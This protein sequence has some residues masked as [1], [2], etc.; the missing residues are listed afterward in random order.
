MEN[1]SQTLAQNKQNEYSE[2]ELESLKVAAQNNIIDFSIYTDERYNPSWLHEEIGKVLESAYQETLKG[3][4]VRIIL[5][6]PPRHGKSETCSIKFPAYVLGRSPEFPIMVSSYS[7]DLAEDFGSKTRD[8]MNSEAYQAVF[9]TRLKQDTKAKG[10]WMTESKGGY[11]S[12]G[13]GGSITGKGFKIGIIDD[14][15]KN[16]KEADSKLIR[17]NVYDWYKSTFYTRQEGYGAIIVIMTR[18]HK[19]DLVGRLLKKQE[20]DEQNPDITEF[21]AWEVIKFPA[22]AINDEQHRKAGEA[23]WK[24]KFSLPMLMNTKN[25]IGS[26][27]WSALYQQEPIASENQEFKEE[28]FQYRTIEE[29]LALQTY[30]SLTIDTAMS[31]N[32]ENDNTG[33]CI[34]FNDRENKWNIKAWKERISPKELI[35]RLFYLQE[36]WNLDAIGVEETI[37]L[38]VVQPFL[39]DEMR[40]RNKFLT[41]TPLKHNGT[42]KEL[43]IRSILPRYESKSVYHIK[44]HC[45]DLEEEQLEFPQS[46]HDDVLDAEAYQTQISKSFQPQERPTYNLQRPSFR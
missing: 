21:D 24:E 20:A 33:F 18:W 30:R 4:K 17:D 42:Q 25:S 28:F 46:T 41:I 13:V 2:E 35:D 43:R 14:P 10:K 40:R 1:Q 3:E 16:R 15:F 27:E 38:Q 32:A 37:Y 5:E 23:L 34:N 29:V 22:I 45:T 39:E 31:K 44:G 7:S 6:V 26:Y 11:T 8:L 36:T 9:K 19:D 12:T